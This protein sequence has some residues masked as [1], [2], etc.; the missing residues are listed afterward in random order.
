M[1]S[2]SDN[3]GANL[4]V[5]CI[6]GHIAPAVR[7]QYGLIEQGELVAPLVHMLFHAA[8]LCRFTNML[9]GDWPPGHQWV[10]IE[11]YD[12]CNCEEC[13]I[14]LQSQPES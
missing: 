1:A 13:L 3:L 10:T 5:A 14:A 8:P 9:P 7:R 2:W 12:E 6:A 11:D 4:A